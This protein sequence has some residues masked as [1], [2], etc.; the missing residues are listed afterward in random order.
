MLYDPVKK[1][2]QVGIPSPYIHCDFDQDNDG[3]LPDFYVWSKVNASC[4]GDIRWFD[5]KGFLL[6][7]ANS[8]ATVSGA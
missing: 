3:V 4:K 6:L 7:D 5:L 2:V 8:T 1:V